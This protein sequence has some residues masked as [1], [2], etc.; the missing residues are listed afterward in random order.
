[1]HHLFNMLQL[2]KQVY[3][4]LVRAQISNGRNKKIKFSENIPGK[5][6]MLI[7]KNKRKDKY[8]RVFHEFL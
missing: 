8:P 1:M 3:I 7:K 2:N 6:T 4:F 5:N